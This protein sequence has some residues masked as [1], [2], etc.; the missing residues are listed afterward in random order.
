MHAEFEAIHPFLDGNGRVGRLLI[1]LFLHSKELLAQ[2]NFYMSQFLES[3]RDEYYA[4]L[5]AISR[6]GDW[7]GWVAFFLQGLIAQAGINKDKAIAILALYNRRK[8]WV[9][10]VTHSQHAVTALDWLFQNPVFKTSDF[11]ASSGIPKPTASRILR[12]IRDEGFLKELRPAS[13]RRAAVLAF[14]ELLNLA[15]GRNVF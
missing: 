10:E 1:P 14:A 8:P 6:D 2:P 9:V 11:V 4:R 12:A 5:L 13:G 7:T 3:H 15:E